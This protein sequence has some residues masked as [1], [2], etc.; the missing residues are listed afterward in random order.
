MNYK[1][2]CSFF[3][4]VLTT[5]LF[6]VETEPTP[7]ETGEKAPALPVRNWIHREKLLPA[8]NPGKLFALFFW[9]PSPRNETALAKAARAADHFQ[10]RGVLFAGIMCETLD[11]AREESSALKDLPFPVAVDDKLEALGTFLRADDEVPIF[12]V[13]DREGRVAW[14]GT[15]KQ[16][17][18]VLNAMLENKFDLA[19]HIR[20]EKVYRA[21]AA[22][23]KIRDVDTMLRISNE[24]LEKHPDDPQMVTINVNLL[25]GNMKKPAEAFK[26]VE[27]ALAASPANPMFYEL[28]IKVLHSAR[29]YEK[30]NAFY[31]R[32]A[33]DF[34]D[35]PLIII[36]FTEL[37]MRQPER[38]TRPENVAF[39]VSAALATPEFQDRREEGLVRLNCANA[40]YYCG[41]PDL[42][43]ESAKKALPLLK[44]APEAEKARE[45]LSYFNRILQVSRSIE[46]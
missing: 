25:A 44:D 35:R 27:N 37:E 15:P 38:E 21:L 5:A 41:R 22:A 34:K 9:T 2:L 31:K 11:S 24:E 16:L 12:V 33:A 7:V 43:F 20:R 40:L 1:R 29:D 10:P 19:E 28:G 8:E 36:K 17:P 26:T 3:A 4:A 23:M 45:A 13:I 14:R 18:A 6:A 46:L 30:L 39:L 32:L 42:A